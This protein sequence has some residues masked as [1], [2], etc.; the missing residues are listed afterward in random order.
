MDW[1]SLNPQRLI[2]WAA[3]RPGWAAGALLGIL[4]LVVVVAAES[5]ARARVREVEQAV[6]AISP[7]VLRPKGRQYAHAFCA[8]LEPPLDPF[9]VLTVEYAL[10]P[11]RSLLG[12]LAGLL[13]VRTE[14]LALYGTLRGRPA[15]ELLWEHAREPDRALGRGPATG[16]WTQHRVELVRSPYALR[17]PN[18]AALEHAFVDLQ[19]R[20]ARH[21]RRVA[22]QATMDPQ[23]VLVIDMAGFP[24]E[25]VAPLA[26]TARAL[27]RAALIA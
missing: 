21:L 15:A 26:A 4:L 25:N 23:F 22:V 2:E 11:H 1:D 13:G 9:K 14:R 27:A 3:Q 24:R 7:S 6:R 5:S 17:G 16:L 20:F 8:T 12:R 18:T 10:R 19:A